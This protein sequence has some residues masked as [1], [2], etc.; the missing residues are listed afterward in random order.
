MTFPAVF[1]LVVKT[2]AQGQYDI[3]SPEGT[4]CPRASV[5]YISCRPSVH[6]LT[7]IASVANALCIREMLYNS[8]VSMIM[9]AIIYHDT[10]NNYISTNASSLSTKSFFF[11]TIETARGSHISLSLGWSQ[12]DYSV[13]N[14][15]EC[16]HHPC[17]LC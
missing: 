1:Y 13:I 4:K 2:W 11:I 15:A 14:C 6:V 16:G 10:H 12:W 7:I 8:T 5:F 3:P 9:D 17:R